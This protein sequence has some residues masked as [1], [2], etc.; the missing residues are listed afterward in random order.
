LSGIFGFAGRGG[1][2]AVIRAAALACAV[3]LL[4]GWGATG[5]RIDTS[6]YPVSGRSHQELVGSV[7]RYGPGGFAYGL[8]VIDFHPRFD[9]RFESGKCRIAAAD[10]GLTVALRLPEWRGPADAPG[11]VTRAAQRFARAIRQHELQHVEI[12]RRYQ[13]LMTAELKRLKP[14]RNCWSLASAARELIA[15]LKR[16]HLAAQRAFDRR[17]H[18]QIRR[19]L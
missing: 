15:R 19:Q 10:T 17:S 5:T 1:R 6:Y 16:Q 9:T 11:G 12:A 8:G 3:P 13:R 4:C 14:D 2:R 7:R 18:K